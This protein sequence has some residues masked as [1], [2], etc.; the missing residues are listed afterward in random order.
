[1]AGLPGPQ[2]AANSAHAVHAM[3]SFHCL[4][5]IRTAGLKA[6]V[7]AESCL[8]TDVYANMLVTAA[9]WQ[10]ACTADTQCPG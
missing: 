10:A 3:A 6:M 9:C 1:M 8:A 4:Q 2:A 7:S 5:A